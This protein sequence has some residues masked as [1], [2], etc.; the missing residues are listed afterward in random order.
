[1][2]AEKAE[3]NSIANI[4]KQH[5]EVKEIKNNNPKSFIA[6]ENVKLD[7]IYGIVKLMKDPE[8]GL[9][10]RDHKKLLITYKVSFFGE[11]CIDWMM[12]NIGTRTRKEAQELGQKLVESHFIHHVSKSAKPFEDAKVLYQFS[13]SLNFCNY[14]YFILFAE[15]GRLS[16]IKS[17]NC[18][19]S[20]GNIIC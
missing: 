15:H 1:M 17:K 5:E 2:C 16:R 19:P 9:E 18:K 6:N 4:L 14:F 8:K 12:N 13:V 10:L 7:D 20:N 3:N 11:S